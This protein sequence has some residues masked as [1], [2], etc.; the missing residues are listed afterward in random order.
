MIKRLQLL[1]QGPRIVIFVFMVVGAL[2]LLGAVTLLLITATLNSTPRQSGQALLETVTVAQLAALPDNDAYPSTVAAGAD[3]TV[4]TAS[5]ATGTIWAI[6]P[7]GTSVTEI[8]NTRE[9][10]D[11]VTAL[12]VRPDNTLLA[13]GFTANGENGAWAV[14]AVTAAGEIAEFGRVTDGQGFVSPF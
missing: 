6:S 13:V 4:Y 10:F 12:A 2:L 5:F 7:D 11:G 3:G 9:R 1:P 8:P 14:Y